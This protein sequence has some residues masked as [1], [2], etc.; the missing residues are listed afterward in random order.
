MSLQLIKPIH[1]VLFVLKSSENQIIFMISKEDKVIY[2]I[3]LYIYIYNILII[4]NI[5][6]N[7]IY[8]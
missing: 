4:Y 2:N 3:Y 8:L 1:Q 7:I 5:Y 6:N